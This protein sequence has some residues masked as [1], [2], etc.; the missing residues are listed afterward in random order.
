MGHK[1]G[2]TQVTV[3]VTHGVTTQVT[4]QVTHGVTTQVTA[5][6]T[7]GVTTQITYGVTTQVTYRVTAQRPSKGHSTGSQHRSHTGSQHRSHT[8]HTDCTEVTGYQI[9]GNTRDFT[10]L[11]CVDF[12]YMMSSASVYGSKFINRISYA[13]RS[14]PEGCSFVTRVANR[15]SL[16]RK[17]HGPHV[18]M[19]FT[20]A[21][22]FVNEYG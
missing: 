18:R 15:R 12:T 19:T 7:Y 3:Q 9:I 4:V 16:P 13:R 11:H 17:K 20:I 1:R 14:R 22:N 8:G 5:R 21:M 6:V 10:Y 2:H